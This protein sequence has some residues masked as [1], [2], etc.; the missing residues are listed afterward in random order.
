MQRGAQ[1]FRHRA[2]LTDERDRLSC[3]R[4]SCGRYSCD[5]VDASDTDGDDAASVPDSA[6]VAGT[7]APNGA[8]RYGRISLL[9]LAGSENVRT[10]QSMGAGLKE[11]GSINK[12]LFALGQVCCHTRHEALFGTRLEG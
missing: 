1:P 5:Q 9:D 2:P 10:S 4:Y 3:D 12:S 7:T 11:A 8:Q 6:S